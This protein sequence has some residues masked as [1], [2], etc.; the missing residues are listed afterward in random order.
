MY[1]SIVNKMDNKFYAVESS[2]I[3]EAQTELGI[4]FPKD[5][6]CFYEEIG[7]GFLSSRMDNFNRIMDPN[8]ICEFRQR[9]GQFA[10]DPELEMYVNYERDRLIFFEVCEGYFLSIGF[11]KRN[12]GKIYSG[13]KMIANSLEEFLIKYQANE[14]YFQD[15]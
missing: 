14:M 9:D 13:S 11:A 12:N 7:Y 3:T 10:N 8:S 4:I 2:R 15:K 6:K 1:E 5:L